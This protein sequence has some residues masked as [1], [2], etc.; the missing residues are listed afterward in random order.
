MGSVEAGTPDT[1]SPAVARR[2]LGTSTSATAG[3]AASSAGGQSAPT[4]TATFPAAGFDATAEGTLREHAA[5]TTNGKVV[6]SLTG[7]L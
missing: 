4:Q 5:G 6:V 2:Q 3:A 7:T 1:P